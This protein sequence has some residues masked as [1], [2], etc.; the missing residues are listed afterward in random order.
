MPSC[1]WCSVRGPPQTH[2][3]N[4]GPARRERRGCREMLIEK[5][6]KRDTQFCVLL[7]PLW[8]PPIPDKVCGMYGGDDGARTR[9]LCRDSESETGNY[10]KRNATDGHFWRY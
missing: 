6:H 7:H 4:R 1:R 2:N 9:D 3:K 5:G 10:Q 8:F